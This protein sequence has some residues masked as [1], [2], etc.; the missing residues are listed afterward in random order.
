MKKKARIGIAVL[1][2]GILFLA[3]YGFYR[4]HFPFGMYHRCDKQLW[5]A[6]I[7]YAEA[8]EGKFPSGE[9]TPEASL[10]LIGKEHAYLLVRR[11]A[12]SEVIYEM[13]ARGELLDPE[14]CGWNYVE[15]LSL[16]S[17]PNLALFW[18]K[19]GLD[20]MGRRVPEGG[21][22]VSYVGRPYEYIP[23]SEWG[24]FL[25]EQRRLLAAEK[26]EV[27]GEG[28]AQPA[29]ARRRGKGKAGYP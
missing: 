28:L 3:A 8:H 1:V 6:L 10:S 27:P 13:L 23:A 5:F 4:H 14:T 21:H 29:D 11:G 7:E 18:D 16:D 20:E 12:S 9:A 19:E 15:R 25:A 17:N 22:F 2:I 26:R 24:G